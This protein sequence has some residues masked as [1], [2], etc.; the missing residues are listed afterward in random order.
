M[1]LYT[2]RYQNGETIVGSGL[3]P[4]GITVGR[5]RMR[6]PYTVAAYVSELAPTGR[7]FRIEDREQFEPAFRAKLNRLGVDAISQRLEA[8]SREHDGRGLV[9]LC[10]EDVREPGTWCHR[11][12]AAAWLGEKLGIEVPELGEGVATEP[13][14]DYGERSTTRKEATWQLRLL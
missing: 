2:S 11:Q 8:I 12:V 14:L 4:V 3:V 1:R 7:L 13:T 6:L 9:L 10:Y 5:P